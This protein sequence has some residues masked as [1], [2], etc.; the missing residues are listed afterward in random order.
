MKKLIFFMPLILML[1]VLSGCSNA[2]VVPANSPVI[3]NP[4]VNTLD[5]KTNTAS[6]VPS[7]TNE[8]ASVN[9][10]NFAFSPDALT[11]K[12]GTTITWINNDSAPHQIK[13]ATFN[14]DPLSQGNSFSFTFKNAGTFNYICSIHPS[15]TGTIVVE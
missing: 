3:K 7:K 14:S 4:A 10:Q 15:M 9:I 2:S 6:T 5:S 12:L 11:I 13:S 8:S 1:V